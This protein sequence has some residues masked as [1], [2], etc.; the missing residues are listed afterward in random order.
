MRLR[1][2][3]AAGASLIEQSFVAPTLGAAL[4][5]GRWSSAIDL[6]HW[7]A[8]LASVPGSTTRGARLSLSTVNL[9]GC[10][11][12]GADR[13][14]ASGCGGLELGVLVARGEGL[15]RP[16]TIATSQVAVTLGPSFDLG[17]GPRVVASVAPWIRLALRRPGIAIEGVGELARPR[18][19]AFGATLRLEV[20][21][22]GRKPSG[23]RIPRGR[24]R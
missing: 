17:L 7:P 20:E 8:G 5:A 24:A 13:F 19:A 3:V 6:A 2:G 1:A 9:T 12:A 18:I 14:A 16:R 10:A 4:V 22:V 21:I 11:R 23:R 15:D